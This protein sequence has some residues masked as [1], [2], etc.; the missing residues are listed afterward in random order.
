[1]QLI[2]DTL[3]Q[4]K[5]GEA[6]VFQNLTMFPLLGGQDRKADYLVLDEALKLHLARVTEVS[7]GGSVPELRFVNE[8]DRRVFLMDGEE[9]VGAKQNRVLNLSILVP[10]K[11]TVV[12]PVSCVEAGRWARQ[13]SEFS[14]SPRVHYSGGRAAKV[15]Q[16]SFSMSSSGGKSP[17]QAA[18]WADIDQKSRRMGAHSPTSAMSEM[19]ERYTNSIEEFV[20]PFSPVSSQIG[21]LF[22]IDGKIVGFDLFD[23]PETQQKLLPKLVR[24]YAL[25]AIDR[26]QMRGAEDAAPRSVSREDAE[27]FLQVAKQ[28]HAESFTGVGEG[29]D[30]RL[31]GE[32]FT[33]G[34]LV[35]D[36]RVIHLCAFRLNSSG[37]ESE[38]ARRSRLSSPSARG[39]RNG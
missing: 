29:Q 2:K 18:V 16:V 22:A 25:D 28:S 7:E 30:V 1:M 27:A 14:S 13:S 4:V 38:S 15:A 11:K 9:L 34:A 32:R 23:N 8:S 37:V 33:G 39:R 5:I 17:D 19:F 20:R 10:A 6:V 26:M 21:S 24:S 31:R 3:E 35:A 36:D 12:I